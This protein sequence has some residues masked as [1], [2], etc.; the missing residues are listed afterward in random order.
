LTDVPVFRANAKPNRSRM[1][2]R[3]F[4]P[5]LF[6]RRPRLLNA[7]HAVRLSRPYSG[8]TREELS[9]L[10]SYAAGRNKAVEIGT[11]MGVSAAVIARALAANGRLFCV[12][13]WTRRGTM[14]NPSWR[15]CRRELAR[16]GVSAKV[17]ILRGFSSDVG[18]ALPGDADFMFIDGDHSWEGIENDWR[19]VKE[20][21]AIGGIVC[22][23]DTAIPPEEPL[24]EPQSVAYF[25]EVICHEPGFEWLQKCHSMNV[26]RRR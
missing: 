1:R 12:D 5:S 22:L 4:W 25:S 6:Y 14:E 8:T 21:L 20:K 24:R 9:C 19:L 17:S 10:S 26:L 13:P 16:Q 7:L 3:Q 18:P 23:H 15:V 11:H 2:M